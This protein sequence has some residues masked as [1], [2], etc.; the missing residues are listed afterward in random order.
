VRPASILIAASAVIVAAA[1]SAPWWMPRHVAPAAGAHID[2]PGISR[3]LAA[4]RAARVSDVAYAVRLRVPPAVATPIAGSLTAEFTLLDATRP[5][6]FDFDQPIDHLIGVRLNGQAVAARMRNGHIVL[7][8]PDLRQGRNSVQFEFVAGDEPLNRHADYLYSLFVP[9]RASR[10]MPVLDQPDLKARWRLALEVPADWVGVSNGRE[11]GRTTANGRVGLIFDETRPIPTYLFAFAAGRFRVETAVRDGRTLRMFHRESDA[12]RLARNASD[13]FTLHARALAW[14][15]SYS[16][17]AYPFGEFS[18]VLIPA[19]QFGGMEHPGAVFYNAN[20]LLLDATAT[21]AQELARATVVAHEVAHMWFGDLVTMRWFDDVWMKEVLANVFASKI[22]APLFPTVNHDLRFL[23]ENYP[24]AYD[25]DRTDG[26]NPIRQD[27]ANLADAGSLYGA[28]IYQ[29]APIVMRQLEMLIGPA[30]FQAGLREFLTLHAF[31]NASW[32]DLVALLDRRSPRDLGGWSRA[33]VSEAG[34]PTIATDVTVNA[35]RIV[36]LA[37]HQHDPRDRGLE[38]PQRLQILVG[39]GADIRTFDAV[40][41][42]PDLEVPGAAGLPAPD[43]ILP[44]GGGLGYGNFVLDARTIAF[45]S[46][47]THTI[48]EPLTRAAAF[49]ALWEA[50]LDGQLSPAAMRAQL[51]AALPVEPDELT[52]QW[53]LDRTREA[54]WRFTPEPD[55]ARI[56]AILEP[57]LRAGLEGAN[58]TREKAAWFAAIRSVATTAPTIAWLER[59]W[60]R[61]DPIDGLPLSEIDEGDLALDLAVRDV[62]DA[63]A[64]LREQRDRFQNADRRARFAFLMPA[65]SS[66]SS[67]RA[68]FFESLRDARNRAHE[69]WVLDAVRYLHHPL[70]HADSERFIRPALELLPEIQRTGDIFFPKRWADATLGGYRSARAAADVHAVLNALPADYPIRLRW[71]LLSAADPLFRAARL[72]GH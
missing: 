67:V 44:V 48:A 11:A 16:G 22:V 62:P 31:A 56:A 7:P 69:S 29:K 53:L 33:W 43:W 19:F 64:I 18:F 50:M 30:A 46:T 65:L 41:D 55:R 40:L 23:L 20:S 24:A 61:E 42:G 2:D 14:M 72:D 51:V 45:L 35:G 36:R 70:R 54:F 5:L 71:V 58:S 60:R 21:R 17:I 12:V 10:A 3:A 52:R 6:L 37:F 38:W 25:V 1:G 8:T 59:V 28:V 57:I 47:R 66:D 34:R 9:A 49:V 39:S 26:A 13:L 63:D 15:E 27:L 32:P 68:R 4:D